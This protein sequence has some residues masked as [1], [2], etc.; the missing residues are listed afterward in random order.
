MFLISKTDYVGSTN[1]INICL[2][3]S[4]IKSFIPVSGCIGINPSALLCPGSYYAVKAALY[5]V[6]AE[7]IILEETYKASVSFI[8]W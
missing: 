5:V 7:L 1:T 3:L 4:T 8:I 6:V 2:I